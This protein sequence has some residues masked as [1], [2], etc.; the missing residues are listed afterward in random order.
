MK[1]IVEEGFGFWASKLKENSS[2]L[3]V[4]LLSHFEI[5]NLKTQKKLE[6]SFN[7]GAQNPSNPLLLLFPP[8]HT[9][10]SYDYRG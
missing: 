2:L 6:S 8:Q 10:S 5:G 4:R 9:H 7:F 1:I 3:Q